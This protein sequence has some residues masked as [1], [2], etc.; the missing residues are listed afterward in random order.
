[1][2]VRGAGGMKALP[3]PPPSML[4]NVEMGYEFF[5][6]ALQDAPA[7]EEESAETRPAVLIGQD[8]DLY[9]LLS[10]GQ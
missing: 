9:C 6:S 7:D 4:A 3:S 2:S 8:T 5:S 10:V 1:M